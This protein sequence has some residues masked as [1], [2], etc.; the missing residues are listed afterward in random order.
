MVVREKAL[1]CLS[2]GCIVLLL[3]ALVARCETLCMI[4]DGSVV[5]SCVYTCI[6]FH[7]PFAAIPSKVYTNA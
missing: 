7:T 4:L 1:G 3:R 2:R 5:R 6:T